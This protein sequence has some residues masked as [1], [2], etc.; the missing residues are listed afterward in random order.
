MQKNK[1]QDIQDIFIK[2]S[3]IKHAL[4]MIWLMAIL[5]IYQEEQL[6]VIKYYMI[7]HLLLLKIKNVID[8]KFLL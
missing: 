6:P 5:K 8:N 4:S 3:E 7:K 1:E 2:M